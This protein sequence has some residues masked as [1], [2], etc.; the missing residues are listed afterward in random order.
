[1]VQIHSP[2]P[3]FPTTY[4]RFLDFAFG[5]MDDFV[6]GQILQVRQ[7]KACFR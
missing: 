2:R 6:V 1:M 5:N 3:F 4:K 7:I